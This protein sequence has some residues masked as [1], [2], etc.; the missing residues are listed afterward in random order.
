MTISS[1]AR[2]A[3]FSPV[4]AAFLTACGG[5]GG[6]PTPPAAPP[7]PVLSSAQANFE[8]AALAPNGGLHSLLWNMPA[9][10]TPSTAGGHFIVDI[11]L[12][13]AASPMSSGA[14]AADAAWTSLSTTLALPSLPI[15][16]SAPSGNPLAASTTGPSAGAP[17][18]VVKGGAVLQVSSDPITK[19]RVT[20]VGDNIQVDTLGLDGS[21]VAYS[22]L[23]SAV[24]PVSVAGQ[25][26]PAPTDTTIAA[27]LARWNLRANPSLLRAG[28]TF[29]A[30]AAY[31]LLTGARKGDTLFASDCSQARVSV[32]PS[33][34]EP[35][36]TGKTIGGS[37]QLTES[38][39]SGGTGNAFRTWTFATDGTVCEIAAQG[40][41]ACPNFGVRYWVSSTPLTATMNVPRATTAYQVYFERSGNIYIGRLQRDGAVLGDNIGTDAAPNVIARQVRVNNA[42]VRSLQAALVEPAPPPTGGSASGCFTRVLALATGY[43]V[44]VLNS[45]TVV[46]GT[47]SSTETS[48]SVAT[49]VGPATFKGNAATESLGTLTSQNGN[50][51]QTRS[52]FAQLTPGV[53]TE[54]G[55]ISPG[56]NGTV[57]GTY[58]PPKADQWM[59]LAAGASQAYSSSITSVFVPLTGATTTV[60]TTDSGTMTFVGRES[61]NVP[62]G[63]YT[64]CKFVSV[65]NAF[66]GNSLS[67]WFIDGYGIPAKTVLVSSPTAG[68]PTGATL[69]N[70]ATSIKVNGVAL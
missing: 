9:S 4:V 28:S 68:A 49:I 45:S 50:V 10:G 30:G 13:M 48:Q 58:N 31:Y 51:S 14:Q 59:T 55:S 7:S 52:Y 69:T 66:P 16:I 6:T 20:Y 67:L 22:T 47:V 61:L 26:I 44:D 23:L 2:A 63:T 40:T 46:V 53:L 27:W 11:A 37:S 65:D 8:G 62:A 64:T 35:C 54:F 38:S 25:S 34:L 18:S 70:V 32:D 12:S 21:T 41:A 56:T 60:T 29:Q 39:F 17:E 3:Y 57:T 19:Q 1:F 43:S 36:Q 33:A 24:D 15:S 42:F 5:G